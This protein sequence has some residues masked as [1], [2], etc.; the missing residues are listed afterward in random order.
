MNMPADD[1]RAIGLAI[2]D[3]GAWMSSPALTGASSTSTAERLLECGAD[4]GW[5]GHGGLIP[6]DAAVRSNA[7]ELAEWLR[8]QGART[9]GSS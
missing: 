7:H 5:V 9:A 8:S 2:T 1:P 4:I 6:L 3:P